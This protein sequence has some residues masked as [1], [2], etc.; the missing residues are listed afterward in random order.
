MLGYSRCVCLLQVI[1][2]SML[3]ILHAYSARWST[4]TVCPQHFYQNKTFLW[5]F[6]F[7]CSH[8]LPPNEV[9]ALKWIIVE[10][11][12]LLLIGI[13]CWMMQICLFQRL[14]LWSSSHFKRKCENEFRQYF[15]ISLKFF[16]VE[17]E[18]TPSIVRMISDCK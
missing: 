2:P 1:I 17:E 15:Q 13:N 4:N 11:S 10:I 12:L 5:F 7:L 6:L 16:V 9:G 8:L 14:E 3:I 18:L